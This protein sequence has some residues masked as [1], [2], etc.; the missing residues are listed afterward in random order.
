[1]RVHFIVHE[2]FEAPGA[3]ETWAMSRG[4]EITYSRVYA[5]EKLPQDAR[6]IDLLIVMGGPQDPAFTVDQ[7]AHFDSNA[8]QALIAS[9]VSFGKA[10]IGVYLGSQLI[11]EALGA[12]FAHSPEKEIGVFP[13]FLTDTGTQSEMFSHFGSQLNVGHWHNDMPGL[14]PEAT[15]IAYSEGCP[16]QIIAY[17]ELVYGFQCHMELTPD[18]VE[19]LIAHSD[20]D[21]S[22]AEKYRFINTPEELRVHDYSEMNRV[23]FTFLDKLESCYCRSKA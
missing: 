21:L 10:I 13:I 23:L 8:E 16:R 14:T 12:P 4:H 15:I 9:A 7:C 17:S 19:L 5:G 6:D 1:M 11:G 20:K 22:Q 3:Y 18:V 2:S